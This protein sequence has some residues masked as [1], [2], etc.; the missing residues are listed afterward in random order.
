MKTL[1]LKVISP[2]GS[3]FEGEAKEVT[4]PTKAGVITVLPG[5]MP[6]VSTVYAGELKI[7]QESL[8]LPYAIYSGLVH[9]KPLSGGKTEVVI[10]AHR[11]EKGEDIDLTKAEEAYARAKKALEEA[12]EDIDFARFESLMDK[13]FNRIKV[14]K[15]YR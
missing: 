15:K 14:G 1:H 9:V 6:L 5:H 7:T 10:L 4:I 13:E 12:E 8:C 3:V 2:I 11:L